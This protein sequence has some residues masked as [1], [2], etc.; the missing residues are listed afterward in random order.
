ME[1]L[2]E[3]CQKPLQRKHG[4]NGPFWSCS[5]Y[6]ECKFS[7]YDLGGAPITLR[8]SECG[9]LLR[10]GANAHGPY[11]YCLNKDK[12]SNGQAHFFDAT[13]QPRKP[14]QANGEFFCPECEGA[15]DYIM[16]KGKPA[17]IC[18]NEKGHESGVARFFSDNG[19]APQL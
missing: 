1:Y 19:G 15:L 13:G 14:L 6:P 12:H 16:V 18:R 11:T 2:C 9:E 17:F 5:G 3:K 10:G 7:L 4:K 8:C